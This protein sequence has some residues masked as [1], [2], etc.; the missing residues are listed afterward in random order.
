M[1]AEFIMARN[2]DSLPGGKRRLPNGTWEVRVSSGYTSDGTQRRVS[3]VAGTEA[4]ADV[5][6]VR[7]SAEMGRAPRMG[8]RLTLDQ[9]FWGVFM[10]RKRA[11][12]TRDTVRFHESNYRTHIG[13]DF[14]G[15]DL[16][17]ITWSRIRSWAARLPAQSAPAYVRTL[18]A[19]LRSAWEDELLPDEPMRGRL[20]L[21]RRDT[22]P[23]PVWDAETVSEA[24]RRLRGADIEALA[25]VMAGSGLSASESRARDWSDFGDG[26]LS[27]SMGTVYTETGGIKEPKNPRRY[28]TVPILPSCASRLEELRGGDGPICVSKRGTRMSPRTV[29]ERWRV[30]FEPGGRLYG[31]PHIKMSRL[32]ATHETLMMQ[33]GVSD[34]LNAAIHGHSQKVAYSNYLVPVSASAVGAAA[35]ADA[36]V[37]VSGPRL[38]LVE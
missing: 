33:A 1:E 2:G 3:R 37:Q 9:Y 28:R 7:L 16:T 35:A 34:A 31:L 18:R 22:R 13:T 15:D 17:A 6:R 10:P 21:P 19:V 38:R 8:D 20:E 24:L 4:E 25:L 23:M 5:M 29:A 30:M 27:V 14:G 36:L 26:C 12:R 11:T 32:R